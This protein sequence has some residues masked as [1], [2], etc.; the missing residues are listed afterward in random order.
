MG[1]VYDICKGVCDEQYYEFEIPSNQS[2]N[3]SF[4]RANKLQEFNSKKFSRYSPYHVSNEIIINTNNEATKNKSR[5]NSGNENELLLSIDKLSQMIESLE[6][7][8]KILEREKNELKEEKEKLAKELEICKN[9]TM[10]KRINTM[11]NSDN[12]EIKRSSTTNLGDKV[13]L[14]FIFKNEIDNNNNNQINYND[15]SKEELNAYKNE[16]FIEVKLRLLKIRHFQPG[17]I[18]KCFY[19]SKEINDWFT[20][21]ELNIKDNSTIICDIT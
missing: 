19:N 4:I 9:R 6:Y 21:E 8:N 10:I 16:M 2:Q 11:K 13:K 15:N 7:K 17:F 12:K 20:L 1:S 5:Y 18:K 3:N 14:I